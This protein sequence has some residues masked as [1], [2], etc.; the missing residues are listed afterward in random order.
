MIAPFVYE[1]QPYRVLFGHGT[2][3]QLPAEAARLGCERLLVL[4]T[5]DQ[6]KPAEELAARLGSRCAATYHGARMHTPVAVTEEAIALVRRARIDGT[7]ALGG[8]STIGL[9]KAIALRTD[10]P[11]I[12]IPTTYAGSEMTQIIGQTEKGGKTTQ[13]TAKVL[14]ET[15]IYD[16]DLTLTLPAKLSITSGINAMA[17]AVEA[18]YATNTN[19]IIQLMAEAGI[20][21]L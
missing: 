16:V 17:H 2:L 13:V 14:P 21:A 19:P 6:R 4:S 5:P 15:V 1:G 12:A 18:L 3:D 9:S 7:I 8:G 20:A 10:L 11:Q